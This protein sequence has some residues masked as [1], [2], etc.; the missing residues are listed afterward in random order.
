MKINLVMM[1]GN[2][3]ILMYKPRGPDPS[4]N[5]TFMEHQSLLCTNYS[6]GSFSP[7]LPIPP[8]GFPVASL[9]RPVHSGSVDFPGTKEEPFLVI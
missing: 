2:W 8:S 3:L 5:T 6:V 7:D 4:W 1:K 9:G